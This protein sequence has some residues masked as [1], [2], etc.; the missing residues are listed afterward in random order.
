MINRL[1][2]A[3]LSCLAAV[4][5]A[6]M[7][8]GAQAQLTSAQQSAMK[9]NC[10]SDFMSKCSGV[11]PGGKD[12]LVCLQKNV[13]TLSPGCQQ[14][15]KSTM[16]APPRAPAATTAV[17]APSAAQPTAAQQSAMKQSCRNDF[18]SHCA[19]VAPGGKDALV[20]LQRNVSRLSPSCRQVVSATRPAAAPATAAAA[21]ATAGTEP[22]A[23]PTPQQ[24]SAIKNT[25]RRDF[26]VHCRGV[27]TG[28]PEAL[29][30]LQSHAPKLTPECKTSLA[31]I[32]DVVPAGAAAAAA[33]PAAA[34]A[35][36]ARPQPPGITPA[37]R[38]LRRVIRNN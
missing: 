32:A 26:Q 19:G 18:M 29:A 5:I 9:S 13:A 10:R 3:N 1:Y 35:P 15:V 38:I 6:A 30:C 17:A 23:A 33:V 2:I 16:A 34:A 36:A 11:T 8:N 21:P 12:A 25:C 22:A 28:G 4:M 20:C 14:V 31:D 7:A 37:G 24:M 27:P